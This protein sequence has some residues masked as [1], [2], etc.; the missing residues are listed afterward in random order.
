VLKQ[1]VSDFKRIY[2]TNEHFRPYVSVNVSSRQ[3]LQED[4]AK[5]IADVLT[6]N[7][8]NAECL[9]IEITESMVMENPEHSS[10]VLKRLKSIGVGL[11]LDDF[12]TGYSSL[13]YLL[14]F[15]FD[16]IKIDSSF[17]QA[18]DRKERLIILRSIVAM[19]HGLGQSLIAEGVELETDVIELNQMG[20]EFAQG[21]FFGR[22]I[23]A[24]EV[25]EMMQDEIRLAGQ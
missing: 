12:G 20:C 8:F 10:Q 22:A 9:K 16:T 24:R 3:L 2:A 14:R 21:F 1:A 17:I 7:E 11:L 15:P 13:A 4:F 25:E 18:R 23:S 5:D 6:K 19:A